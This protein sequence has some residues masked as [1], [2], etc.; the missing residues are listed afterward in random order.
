MKEEN[1]DLVTDSYR[2]LARYRKHFFQLLNAHW[3]NEFWQTEMHTAEPIVPVPNASEVEMAAEK[4]KRHKSPGTDQTPPELIKAMGGTIHS[5]IHKD[6]HTILNKV[7]LPTSWKE[8]I[9]VPIYRGNQ[10]DCSYCRGI[11][12]CLLHTKF[13][14]TFCS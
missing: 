1:G 12:I 7:R 14:P 5:E 10:T 9:G 11:Y 6:V 8:L 2:S 3:A 4:L 13:Y